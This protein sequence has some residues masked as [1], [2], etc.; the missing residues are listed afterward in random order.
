MFL[1]CS[2]S[3]SGPTRNLEPGT[4][5]LEYKKKSMTKSKTK[6]NRH[7]D[8]DWLCYIGNG[9]YSCLDER[10]HLCKRP[11]YEEMANKKACQYFHPK[12]QATKTG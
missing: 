2:K 11:V 3:F 12:Q 6:I 8:C 9:E 7:I 4:R 5:N 1:I 10:S